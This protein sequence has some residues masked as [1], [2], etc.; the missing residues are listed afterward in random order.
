MKSKHNIALKRTV[1]FLS[2]VL[3]A[4][5]VPAWSF[6][7]EYRG[8]AVSTDY[9]AITTSN[10]DLITFDLSI[11]GHSVAP[12]RVDLSLIENQPEWEHAFVGGG[13]L[14]Q[15]VFVAPEAPAEAQLWLDP[16]DD[17]APGTYR[18]AIRAQG[19]SGR[20]DLPLTVSIGDELP[21]RL[22]LK[23]ELPALSGSPTADFTFRATLANRSAQEGLVN[24][25]A[26]APSGFQVSFKK[27][28]GNQELSSMPIEAGA[29]EELEVEVDP[30]QE[31]SAGDYPIR[32]FAESGDA[33]A[34]ADL[35]VTVKGQPELS[36]NGPLGRLSETAV[37]GRARAINLTIENEG[38]ADAEN[39]S[40]RGTAP[41]NWEVSFEPEEVQRI[42]AGESVE[43][44]ATITP[45]SEAITGDYNV[46]LRASSEETSTSE[47][48]RIT[49]RTSTIWGIVAV[50]VIALALGVVV[51]A[52]N[53]YGRR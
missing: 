8:I 43:V 34:E 19:A 2:V 48:F 35:T 42:P 14:I 41:R 11:A 37:A 5:L 29:E 24:L 39:V 22:S 10:R 7:Q 33:V 21:R 44:V 36:L 45:S 17:A 46:T 1:S 51:L 15:A 32:V 49:V 31:V 52:I 27:Q 4:L 38:V 53:R 28:Y 25:R 47:R 12:Q 20:F 16:P 30:P 9:P 26:E 18:F 50:I 23:P 3:L 6:G 40:F 13:G